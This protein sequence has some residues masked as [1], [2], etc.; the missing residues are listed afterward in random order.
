MGVCVG[1]GVGV[2]NKL[3]KES[4]PESV[5]KGKRTRMN[6][7]FVVFVNEDIVYDY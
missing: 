3:T 6:L 7:I 2:V 5:N 4:H 1:M